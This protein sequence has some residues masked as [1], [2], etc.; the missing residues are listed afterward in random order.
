MESIEKEF[1]KDL[2]KEINTYQYDVFKS[3]NPRI[4][5]A[6]LNTLKSINNKNIDNDTLTLATKNEVKKLSLK[7][8]K[9]KTFIFGG[10]FIVK[11]R[12]VVLLE[13]SET[14]G[15][16]YLEDSRITH[17]L[18]YYKIGLKVR[19]ESILTEDNIKGV[20]MTLPYEQSSEN[21]LFSNND[22]ITDGKRL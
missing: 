16:Y 22:D 1:K 4:Y 19:L 13:L 18:S 14:I 10:I 11:S 21:D 8:G 9:P 17:Q 6:I 5:K 7:N 15:T 2:L 3:S 20:T 12:K